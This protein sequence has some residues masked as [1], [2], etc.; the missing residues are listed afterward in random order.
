MP[1]GSLFRQKVTESDKS[2]HSCSFREVTKAAKVTI[3][4][5]L[6]LSSPSGPVQNM[7]RPGLNV[8]ESG[9]KR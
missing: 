9:P 3:L 1:P 6:P 4:V 8:S 7:G 2:G 5:V